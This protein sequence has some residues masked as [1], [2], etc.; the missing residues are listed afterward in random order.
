MRHIFHKLHFIQFATKS[1]KSDKNH[2]TNLD[3]VAQK[4]VTTETV[5]YK[6]G[7]E[8]DDDDVKDLDVKVKVFKVWPND[9]L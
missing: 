2:L 6:D 1:S 4:N 8:D 5:W 7:M 9:Q 3:E